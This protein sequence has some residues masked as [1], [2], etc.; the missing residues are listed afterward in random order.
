[1][2][3]PLRINKPGPHGD[4][5]GQWLERL[6]KLIPSE[7]VALYLAGLG[8]A[9]SWSSAWAFVCLVVVVILRISAT[10][11]PAKGVQWLAVALSAVSFVIWVYAIGGEAFGISVPYGWAANTVMVW[12]TVVPAIYK[13][14]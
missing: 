7:A 11:D 9:G 8:N 10:R 2:P 1:M 12:V 6:V 4:S 14:D 5:L 3:A 13:G